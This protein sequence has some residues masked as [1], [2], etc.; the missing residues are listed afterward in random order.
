MMKL[1]E[2]TLLDLLEDRD[3]NTK[4]NPIEM[5]HLYINSALLVTIMEFL[6]EQL[7]LSNKVDEQTRTTTLY[8][9]FI[10]PFFKDELAPIHFLKRF[11]IDNGAINIK[12]ISKA[13]EKI[14]RETLLFISTES[15]FV[16]K[17]FIIQS[18][19]EMSVLFINEERKQV[20]RVE[21]LG[22]NGP[23]LY[24]TFEHLDILF[25][26]NYQ[27][28]KDMVVD[29]TQTERIYQTGGVN[30]Q[31]GYSTILLAL[32][33][34]DIEEGSSM[35]DLG[36]GYGRVGLVC[37]LLRPD[38]SFIGYEF[39][40]HRVDI[41]NNASLALGLQNDLHF[42]V[43]DLS[44]ESFKIPVSDIYYLYDPFTKETYDYV[45]K[46]ILDVSKRQ[47]VTIV[48]KG[49]AKGWFDAIAKDNS[50]PK[51]QLIDEG[52]LCIFKSA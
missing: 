33:S 52:N 18:L 22:H 13:S 45:L 43:Q 20:G 9:D 24:R 32:D 47:K 30:V 10:T 23:R 27:L 3:S 2:Q 31:S 48:T 8:V 4:L 51:P 29:T 1:S 14:E 40:P 26:L 37:S 7:W 19:K 25:K 17:K 49:N 35:V 34:L 15:I 6:K 12:K 41:S 38:V 5:A 28:D 39:V 21:S 44:L 50:W 11:L 46:Q 16:Q 42:E 36:S